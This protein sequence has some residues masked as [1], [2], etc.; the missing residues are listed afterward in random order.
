MILKQVPERIYLRAARSRSA[1]ET[2][3]RFVE[4]CRICL[5]HGWLGSH[6]QRNHEEVPYRSGER[7]L[8]KA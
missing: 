3:A 4:W 6:P 5:R 7:Q 8:L 1:N 2:I